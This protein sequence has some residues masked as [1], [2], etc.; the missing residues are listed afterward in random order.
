LK[1]E[2]I[3][4]DFQVKLGFSG[5][6]GKLRGTP[7]N[8]FLDQGTWKQYPTTGPVNLAATPLE[9][10]KRSFTGE[11]QA[12]FAQDS[13]RVPVNQVQV[14]VGQQ[15]LGVSKDVSVQRHYSSLSKAHH[16][17]HRYGSNQIPQSLNRFSGLHPV[18][19]KLESMAPPYGLNGAV[20]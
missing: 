7:I 9:N 12:H 3:T 14:L 10:V 2:P 5:P 15:V 11:Y 8:A 4:T 18:Q 20:R 1:I 17:E 6:D 16:L 13:H 19:L